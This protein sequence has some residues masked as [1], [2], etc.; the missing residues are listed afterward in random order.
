VGLTLLSLVVVLPANVTGSEVDATNGKIKLC[1]AEPARSGCKLN[2]VSKCADW[3]AANPDAAGAPL[4]APTQA[5]LPA[6]AV[7]GARSEC[8]RCYC[9]E[10][11]DAY[12]AAEGYSPFIDSRRD[13][14]AA[15]ATCST[16]RE[17][18]DFCTK[19]EEVGEVELTDLDWATLANVGD[20][21]DAMWGHAVFLF[22]VTAFVL[23]LTGK[24]NEDAVALRIRFQAVTGPGGDAT[25]VV[26]T[27][28]PGTPTGTFY[29]YLHNKSRL[30]MK[31]LPQS[32]L[33]RIES[34]VFVG[35]KYD[36]SKAMVSASSVDPARGPV[37]A[38]APGQA[39]APGAD[40]DGEAE[41]EA[42]LPHLGQVEVRANAWD[43]A[44]AL[45]A[46][47]SFDEMVTR[48]VEGVYGKD[49]VAEVVVVRDVGELEK[50]YREYEAT[51]EVRGRER[52]PPPP[53][54][55]PPPAHPPLPA[56]P[57]RELSPPRPPTPR[58]VPSWR[59]TSTSRPSSP[60]RTSPRGRRPP[61]SAA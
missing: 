28:I 60:R 19:C 32:V 45:L 42:L 13:L 33:Q 51:K 48:E 40:D 3:R 24:F 12:E 34:S 46:K 20:R 56:S 61:S 58:R 49:A 14:C 1:V 37:A 5:A 25:S 7:C 2:S 6:A 30:L 9:T 8:L 38:P 44:T 57:T 22:L 31:L 52:R 36:A 4:Y 39:P 41:A 35:R 15:D 50:L 16:C 21:D 23:R 29:E 10:W 18:R 47:G 54:P 55:R 27:D 59:T 11:A 43:D 53:A 17:S 26:V